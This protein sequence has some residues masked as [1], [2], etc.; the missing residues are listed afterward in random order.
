MEISK[1]RFKIQ[2]FAMHFAFYEIGK[3]TFSFK[4][5]KIVSTL[6]KYTHTQQITPPPQKK[7]KRKKSNKFDDYTLVCI[8]RKIL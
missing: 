2:K 1:I 3:F 8:T 6:Q 4:Q 5:T 7:N